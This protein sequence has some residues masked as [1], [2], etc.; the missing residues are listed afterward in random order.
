MAYKVLAVDDEP[1][2][3]HV[4][5]SILNDEYTLLFA[6]EGERALLMAREQQPDIIL[7]DVIMP[8]M[9]GYELCQALKQDPDTRD[10]PVVFVSSLDENQ[11]EIDGLRCGAVEFLHKPVSPE[12]VRSRIQNI[13]ERNRYSDTMRNIQLLV[14]HIG[15]E[16]GC[17]Q[18]D[19]E[20]SIRLAEL[21][22]LL[23]AEYGLPS[24]RVEDIRLAIPLAC[25]NSLREISGVGDAP[26]TDSTVTLSEGFLKRTC[27]LLRYRD[28]KWDPGRHDM[29]PDEVWLYQLATA[30]DSGIWN[31]PDSLSNNIEQS[32]DRVASSRKLVLPDKV[33]SLF[34]D[35]RSKIINYFQMLNQ[36]H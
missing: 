16:N 6:K 5:R 17:S 36:H 34:D 21:T 13:L 10:I 9:N 20:Q 4:I 25:L 30:L 23:A 27:E 35:S 2:N 14:D 1:S 12:L 31:Q 18:S 8:G 32:F 3:L 33:L 7:L 29:I 11:S 26:D 15:R 19:H 28:E 22:Q 24:E